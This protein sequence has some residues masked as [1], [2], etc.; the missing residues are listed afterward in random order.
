MATFEHGPLSFYENLVTEGKLVPGDSRQSICLP[1]VEWF[2]ERLFLEGIGFAKRN[3]FSIFFN[4]ILG[5]FF[6][7]MYKPGTGLKPEPKEALKRIARMDRRV[8]WI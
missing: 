5:L 3:I 2:N 8:S 6:G 7:Y 4:Q 1:E